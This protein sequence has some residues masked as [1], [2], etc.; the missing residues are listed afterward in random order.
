MKSKIKV[1]IVIVSP[2]YPMFPK[3]EQQVYEM[4]GRISPLDEKSG[5]RVLFEKRGSLLATG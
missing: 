1:F 3:W 4:V 5:G 2:E